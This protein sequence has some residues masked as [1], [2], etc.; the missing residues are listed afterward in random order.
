MNT[1][2]GSKFDVLTKRINILVIPQYLS[3]F[4]EFLNSENIWFL[5]DGY[6]YPHKMLNGTEVQ[7][8]PVV[9]NYDEKSLDKIRMWDSQIKIL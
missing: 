8:C 9:I 1:V 5:N 4:L 7:C 3:Q 6:S 2:I